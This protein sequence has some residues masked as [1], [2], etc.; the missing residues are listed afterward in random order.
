MV[1]AAALLAVACSDSS[2][3]LVDTDAAEREILAYLIDTYPGV[4]FES[5]SCPDEVEA[6]AGATFTCTANLPD[7]ELHVE[8]TQ[9]DDEGGSISYVATEA[10]VLVAD[11]KAQVEGVVRPEFTGGVTVD[12]GLDAILVVPPGTTFEC[13]ATGPLDPLR[14]IRVTVVDIAGNLEITLV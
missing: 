13:S 8:V 1:A 7:D 6:D 5:I 14:I 12:C 9:K 3:R 10:V 11:A 4:T 2:P